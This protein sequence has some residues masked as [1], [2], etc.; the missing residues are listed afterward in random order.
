MSLTKDGPVDIQSILKRQLRKVHS[1]WANWYLANGQYDMA[2]EQIS[3]AIRY[4]FTPG[5]LVKNIL[6]RLSPR[7][8]RSLAMRRGF[9]AQ[10]F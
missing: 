1:G 10:V 5:L 3:Q 4:G 7:T 9:D 2:Q 8:A 6:A